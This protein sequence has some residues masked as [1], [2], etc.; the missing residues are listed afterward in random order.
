MPDFSIT[1]AP[2]TVESV[3]EIMPM[4]L[5][6]HAEI[7]IFPLSIDKTIERVWSALAQPWVFVAKDEAGTLLGSLALVRHEESA[8]YSDATRTVLRDTWFYVREP[9]RKGR[10]GLDLMGRAAD[11]ARETKLTVLVNVS[12]PRRR[13]KIH[14]AWMESELVG[15]VPLN[16]TIQLT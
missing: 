15:W 8:W 7:G 11:A 12:N 5:E 16:H 1:I 14:G 4:L 3:E 2:P 6:M 10:V 13:A 9:Y